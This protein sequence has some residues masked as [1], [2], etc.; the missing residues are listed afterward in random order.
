MRKVSE[1]YKI[2][3]IDLDDYLAGKEIYD[4]GFLWWDYVHL[5]SYGHKTAAGFVA[6]SIADHVQHRRK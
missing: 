6:E 4:S 3:C 2:P 5:T 1:T